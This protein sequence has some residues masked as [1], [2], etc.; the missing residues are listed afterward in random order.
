MR[1]IYC[2]TS[3]LFPFK[4]LS[5]RGSAQKKKFPLFTYILCVYFFFFFFL[6]LVLVLILF[7]FIWL[8]DRWS[9]ASFFFVPSRFNRSINHCGYDGSIRKI[10][11]FLLLRRDIYR[12]LLFYVKFDRCFCCC[13]C[14]FCSFDSVKVKRS[15]FLSSCSIKI[16]LILCCCSCFFLV[17][18]GVFRGNQCLMGAEVKS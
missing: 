9:F 10:F 6:L 3:E 2:L 15:N 16:E 18:W 13:C 14:F 11:F 8:I 4:K 12:I 7:Y 17:F 1:V 5:F